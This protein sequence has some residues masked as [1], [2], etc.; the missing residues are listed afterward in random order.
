MALIGT[1]EFAIWIRSWVHYD[2]LAHSLYRQTVNS[3]N[4]RNDFETKIINRLRSSNMENTPIQ[5]S[6]GIRLTL[7]DEK[8]NPPLTMSKLEELLRGYFINQKLPDDTPNILK[9]I[10]TQRGYETTINKR[11]KKNTVQP[12]PPLP[13]PSS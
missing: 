5:I 3:R 8:H 10:K 9:Y 2:N 12:L 6:G 1:E 13:P 4:V 11:L 7:Q